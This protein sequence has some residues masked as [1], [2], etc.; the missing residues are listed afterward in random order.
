MRGW[1]TY[2]YYEMVRSSLSSYNTLLQYSRHSEMSGVAS[3]STTAPPTSIRDRRWLSRES[4]I[5][6]ALDQSL[7]NAGRVS[8]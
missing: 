1:S 6:R 3:S 4:E 8:T 7:R 5:E 2:F